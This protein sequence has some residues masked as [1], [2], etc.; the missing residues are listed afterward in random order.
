MLVTCLSWTALQDVQSLGSA[1][2]PASIAFASLV[3]GLARS[4]A[5]LWD[6]VS[7]QRALLE[8]SNGLCNAGLAEKLRMS[9]GRPV[10][11]EG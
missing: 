11:Q 5:R 9:A 7:S 6:L 8:D 3:I 4:P 10:S 1:S 2:C